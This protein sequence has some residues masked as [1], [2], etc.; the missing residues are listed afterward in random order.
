MEYSTCE[1]KSIYNDNYVLEEACSSSL[2]SSGCQ[3]NFINEFILNSYSKTT[4]ENI[5]YFFYLLFK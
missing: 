4:I 2:Y 1:I 3:L 5:Y